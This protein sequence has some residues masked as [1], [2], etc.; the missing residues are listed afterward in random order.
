VLDI[1]PPWHLSE[2]L[3]NSQND[4]DIDEVILRHS[5]ITVEIGI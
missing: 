5:E 2:V 1:E 3:G 4:V